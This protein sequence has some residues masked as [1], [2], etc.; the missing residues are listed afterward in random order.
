MTVHTARLLL[1][2]GTA[3]LVTAELHHREDFAKQL[4]AEIPTNWPPP[5]ND[6]QTLKWCLRYFAAHEASEGWVNWYF[7]LKSQEEGAS[8]VA[9]GNGGFRGKATGD[10]TVELGY[11]ILPQFQNTGYA[12]EAVDGLIHWAFS[13]PEVKRII[14]ETYPTLQKSIRVLEKNGFRFIG[15]GGD[16]QTLRYERL[17]Y[18][19]GGL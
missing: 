6:E 16:P 10:G 7:V 5:L 8:P 19:S 14:A 2:A 11:S 17:P 18:C 9:V 15:N 12:S 3:E 4:E 13:H 1:V